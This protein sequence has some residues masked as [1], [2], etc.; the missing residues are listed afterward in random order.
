MKYRRTNSIQIVGYFDFDYAGDDRK[1][2][3]GYLFIL[4]EELFHEKAQDKLS[5]HHTQCMPSL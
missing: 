2:V 3:L 4:W 5:L 1:S